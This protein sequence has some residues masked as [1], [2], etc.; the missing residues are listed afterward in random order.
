[1]T[2]QNSKTYESFSIKPLLRYNKT[3]KTIEVKRSSSDVQAC[4]S[5]LFDIEENF[6]YFSGHILKARLLTKLPQTLTLNVGDRLKLVCLENA[7]FPTE[8]RWYLNDAVLYP[9]KDGRVMFENNKRELRITAVNRK[10]AGNITCFVQNRFGIDSTT[11]ILN[12]KVFK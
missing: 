9:T 12:I 10:D 5:K 8:I 1:M 4:F 11:C 7:L 2:S 6:S 3:A